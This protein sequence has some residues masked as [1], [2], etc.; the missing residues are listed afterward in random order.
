MQVRLNPTGEKNI[1]WRKCSSWINCKQKISFMNYG[2]T[3]QSYFV[4][5]IQT[6]YCPCYVI[7]IAITSFE[8]CTTS[9]CLECRRTPVEAM[10]R[11][12]LK[13]PRF[14][15]P[16][17]LTFNQVISHTL[18]SSFTGHNLSCRSAKTN[19]KNKTRVK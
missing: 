16:F 11:E 9:G 2:S 19:C 13:D 14:S 18:S 10:F 4:K 17:V 12:Q 1:R 6:I 8:K 7:L 3:R 15:F 5:G